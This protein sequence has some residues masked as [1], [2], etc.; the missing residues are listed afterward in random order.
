MSNLNPE[1]TVELS[2]LLE[3]VNYALSL[4]FT[5]KWRHRF[6]FN[7]INVFQTKLLQSLEQEKPIKL[8]SLVSLYTKKHKYDVE[9]VKDFFEC[10][11]IS[12]YYPLVYRDRTYSSSKPH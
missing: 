12:L 5:E 3:Q 9:V 8:S 7:I 2:E 4:K 1:E 10:I 11:D 6:S